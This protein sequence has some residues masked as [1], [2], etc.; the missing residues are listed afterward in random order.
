MRLAWSHVRG[1]WLRLALSRCPLLAACGGSKATPTPQRR[2]RV[3]GT[4]GAPG[5]PNATANP[6]G[7]G[8]ID[9]V[10][11][12]FLQLITVY[13]SQGLDAAKQFARDQGLVTKQDE[14]RITLVLDSDDPAVDG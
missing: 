2:Q 13:Q 5:G 11:K 8:N 14:V 12:V 10:D 1:M 6:P 9:K 3:P 4:S 7:G